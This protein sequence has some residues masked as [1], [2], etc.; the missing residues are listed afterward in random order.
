MV[1]LR[2]P[3][4]SSRSL[5]DRGRRLMARA[6]RGG[7]SFSILSGVTFLLF[8]FIPVFPEPL[9][10]TKPCAGQNRGGTPKMSRPRP[11]PVGLFSCGETDVGTGWLAQRKW[12]LYWKVRTWKDPSSSQ[13]HREGFLEER[14]KCAGR[15]GEHMLKTEELVQRPSS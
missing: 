10:S 4:H 7:A 8:S 5:R 13:G 14:G 3:D 11:C 2:T 6:S 9:L 15:K 12:R 1:L